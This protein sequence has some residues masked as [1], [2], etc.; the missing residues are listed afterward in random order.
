MPTDLPRIYWDACL[1]LSYINGDTNRVPDIEALMLLGDKDFEIIT[2]M[3][4]ITEVAFAQ[5]EQEQKKLDPVIEGRIQ[6]LWDAG[7]PIHLVE[8]FELICKKARTLMR[9][10]LESGWS[11]RLFDAVH[12]ATADHLKVI[13]F[14]TYD[15]R[16]ANS[17]PTTETH[18]PII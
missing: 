3:L 14:H 9:K 12:L 11:L 6:K 7:S 10:S 2:S 5:V 18:F 16:L 1:P 4:S 17:A 13:E 8:F 15:D